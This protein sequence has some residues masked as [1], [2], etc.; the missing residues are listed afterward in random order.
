MKKC[1]ALPV[2]LELDVCTCVITDPAAS[3][4]FPE[5]TL[6]FAQVLG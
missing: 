3:M 6:T 2:P 4:Q 1:P 5:D